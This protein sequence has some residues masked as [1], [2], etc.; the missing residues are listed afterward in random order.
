MS[1][2]IIQVEHLKRTFKLGR[3]ASVAALDDV[4]CELRPGT[5]LA[6]VGE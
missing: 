1:E 3:G 2:P 4:T 6:V 5:C